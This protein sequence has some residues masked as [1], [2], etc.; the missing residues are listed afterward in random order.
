VNLQDLLTYVGDD[1]LKDRTDLISGDPDELW[2]DRFIVSC[3]NEAQRI[4]A[5]RAWILIDVGNATAGQITLVENQDTY[6]LHKSVLRVYEAIPTDTSIPL[7]RTTHSA[8]GYHNADAADF[9]DA[10]AAFSSTPARP[11]AFATDAAFRKLQLNRK[12]DAASAGL[13]LNLK[14]ARLPITPLALSELAGIPEVPEEYHQW[15]GDYAAGCCLS[16]PRADADMKV[17]GRAMKQEFFAR[18]GEAK[19]DR[20]RAEAAPGDFAFA[21]TTAYS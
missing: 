9:F 6:D 2:S 12:P 14:V 5:R 7:G 15:L 1:V 13:I 21:S 20:Q 16:M 10:N 18:V 17:V 11:G 19:Q 3:L 8:I 4:L